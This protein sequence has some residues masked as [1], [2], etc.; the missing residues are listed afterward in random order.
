MKRLRTS[1]AL[2]ARGRRLQNVSVTSTLPGEG[3][4]TLAANLAALFAASGVRTLLID[5]DMRRASLSRAFARGTGVARSPQ[6]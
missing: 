4:S 5:G 6:W 3:K 1:I 2:A